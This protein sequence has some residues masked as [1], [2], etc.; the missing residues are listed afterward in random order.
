RRDAV[1][2]LEGGRAQGP[3]H[4]VIAGL[5]GMVDRSHRAP[6]QAGDAGL[7]GDRSGGLNGLALGGG[8]DRSEREKQS[9]QQ[10]GRGLKPRPTSFVQV[11]VAYHAAE[12]P[13]RAPISPLS[14]PKP[15]PA[16]KAALA[17]TRAAK[18]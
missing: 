10:A 15:T 7:V 9:E 13:A 4:H 12:K 1:R 8:A 5:I 16:V 11:V 2:G 6:H 17:P 3:Q 14:K 18:D